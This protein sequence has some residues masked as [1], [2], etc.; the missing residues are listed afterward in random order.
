M[1]TQVLTQPCFKMYQHFNIH[2]LHSLLFHQYRYQIQPQSK[3]TSVS[4]QPE[5]ASARYLSPSTIFTTA[6]LRLLYHSKWTFSGSGSI[7]CRA[8]PVII[9][10]DNCSEM[11]EFE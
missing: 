6:R 9:V 4:A 5:L 7:S 8:E 2:F 3:N 10:C 11:R 1:I